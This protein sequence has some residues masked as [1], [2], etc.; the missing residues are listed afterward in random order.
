MRKSLLLVLVMLTL[1]AC[2][3]SS[4]VSKSKFK[5][6]DEVIAPM[7]REMRAF[8]WAKVTKVENDLVTLQGTQSGLESVTVTCADS[9]LAMPGADFTNARLSELKPDDKIIFNLESRGM[10]NKLYFGT[11]IRVDGGD[12]YIT[13]DVDSRTGRRLTFDE[14]KNTPT[15]PSNLFRP[16]PEMLSA[17]CKYWKSIGWTGC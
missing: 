4:S 17:W 5:I 16:S 10:D 8:F 12:L 15:Q 9:I 3:E 13:G 7:D 11:V 2:G 14:A 6:G 1:N